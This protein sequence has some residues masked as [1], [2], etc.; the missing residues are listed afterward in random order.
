MTVIWAKAANASSYHL[1]VAKDAGFAGPF[2]VNDST[3]TDTTKALTGLSL[4]TK[5]Y[6][7]VRARN[8]GGTSAF[9]TARSFTTITGIPGT[10]SLVAPA[11]GTSGIAGV[12][13]FRWTRPTPGAASYR[14]QVGTD[15]TFATAL[16]VNDSTLVDTFKTVTNLAYGKKY[17]WRVNGKDLGGTGPY[18]AVW[19]LRTL[20]Q[21]PSVPE[22]LYPANGQSGL[23][24]NPI[25]RWTRPAGATS[26]HLQ[27]GIDSTF[28]GGLL[29]DDPAVTDT[30]K[31]LIGL[32]LQATYYWRLN[33]DNVGG[34]SPW[35]A[36]HRF[37]VGD[38]TPSKVTLWRP[39]DNAVVGTSANF[40][41]F[42]SQPGVTRYWFELA[43]D[44]LFTFRQVDTNV[45]DTSKITA[46][47]SGQKYWWKVRGWNPTGW[48]PYSNVW[49][50]TA[51]GTV[52]IG[53]ERPVPTDYAL[54]QNYPNPFNPSTQ[55]EF[56]VPKESHVTLEVYSMIGAKVATLVDEALPVGYHTVRFDASRL[57]SGLYIYR[58]TAGSFTMTKKMVL[59]R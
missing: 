46:L 20:S 35:T 12:A 37:V 19:N 43:A 1:Q 22:I 32:T 24:T 27:F 58:L 50:V 6:W 41:W 55:I 51:S 36:T 10:P 16:L 13:T 31:A 15:S 29:I 21:D 9:A 26:F 48:G 30:S 47:I 56:A 59:V 57:S 14:L 17:F 49:T 11:S 34:T 44:S 23:P 52:D 18:S 40:V 8:A 3:L 54:N 7:R 2:V 5:H 28:A 25:L 53:G 4:G 39:A 38:L 45:V 33:A 42:R